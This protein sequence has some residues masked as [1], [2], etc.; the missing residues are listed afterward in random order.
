M[1]S[2]E[3]RL[4]KKSLICESLLA[5]LVVI[6]A[7]RLFHSLK[8]FSFI[9]NNLAVLTA[10]FLLYVPIGLSLFKKEKISYVDFSLSAF[11]KSLAFGGMITL[12]VLIPALGVNHIYQTGILHHSFHAAPFPK[13]FSFF[14]FE[15]VVIALPEE[16]FFRGYLLSRANVILRKNLSL[17]GTQV[18]WGLP[19]VSL[20]FALSHTLIHYQWWHLL[21]FFPALLFGW[22][23]ERTKTITASVFFH[24]ACN[25]FAQWV[26]LHYQ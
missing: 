20:I 21:I 4:N 10:L 13:W 1:H 7:S 25:L 8:S 15:L 9:Q 11:L 17:L 14:I 3:T 12:L 16:F 23:R 18:G 5:W 22:L 26:F 2:E 19:V 6:I 24:A